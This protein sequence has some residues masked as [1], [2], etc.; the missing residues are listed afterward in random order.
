MENIKPVGPQPSQIP[1]PNFYGFP[2]LSGQ[3][4]GCFPHVTTIPRDAV[5]H[6]GARSRAGGDARQIFL[7]K[8]LFI[9]ALI[10]HKGL[11][12]SVRTHLDQEQ[13]LR[14]CG[15]LREANGRVNCD[16]YGVYCASLDTLNL[17]LI[18]VLCPHEDLSKT[19][20]MMNGFYALLLA[21]PQARL[22]WR[23]NTKIV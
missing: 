7:R 11:V 21:G 5:R 20:S 14:A 2:H 17:L 23:V 3:L 1:F 4:P 8:L 13:I 15:G 19:G 10:K 9:N 6:G 12:K 22:Y 18:N 16:H